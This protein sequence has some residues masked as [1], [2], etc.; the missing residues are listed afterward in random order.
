MTHLNDISKIY[1]EQ[2]AEK[3]DDSYLE[4]DMK[5]RQK[6]NEKAIADMKK[7]K[8][9]TVPRWM[10]EGKKLDPVG[11]EDADIDNDGDVDKSDKYLHK[12]R[13][14]IGKAIDKKKDKCEKCDED[15]CECDDK[16][17]EEGVVVTKRKTLGS[18]FKNDAERQAYLKKLDQKSKERRLNKLRATVEE[19]EEVEEGR[20]SDGAL[21][22]TDRIKMGDGS[23]KSLK[24][25]DAILKDKKPVRKEEVEQID[26]LRVTKLADKSKVKERAKNIK[27]IRDKKAAL[28]DLMKHYKGMKTGVY[29][30]YEPEGEMV[31]E[32]IDVRKQSSK[33]K[34]LGRGSSINPDAKKTGYESPAEFRKTEKKLAPY[35]EAKNVHGE[36]EV[37]SGNIG[38]LA[39]KASKR[40]DTDVDGDVEHN[41]KH[42]GEYGEFVPTPDGKGK[43]FTG[44][45][46]VTKES[47][48]NWRQDLIEVADEEG[49]KQIKE[50][51][52][53]QKNKISINPKLGEAIENLGGT[54]IEE[55]EHE[56]HPVD[57]FE[58][59]VDAEVYFLDDD[60]IESVVEEVILESLEDGYDLDY[61]IESIVESAD[62]SLQ[63]L[64]EVTN[65]AKVAALR[66]R[67][68]AAAA[69]GEGQTSGK[70]AGSIAK[71]RLQKRS[72]DASAASSAKAARRKERIEKVKSTAKKVGSAIKKAGV[73]AAKGA[74]KAG[75]AAVKG[76]TYG[77][78]YTAGS[79]VRGARK[80][81]SAAKKGYE[82]GRKKESDSTPMAT[83]RA[84]ETKSSETPKASGKARGGI[85]RALKKGLKAA[86]RGTAKVISTGAGAVKAGADYVAKRAGDGEVKKKSE[87]KAPKAKKQKKEKK[88]DKSKKLD[89][90][91]SSIRNEEVEQIDE[92]AV[93]KKQQRFMGMVYAAK[94]GEAPASAE[95]A[96]AAAG[97]SKKDAKDFAS[98][99]HK[100]LPEVKESMSSENEMSPQEIQLRKKSAMIDKRLASIRQRTAQK[101]G[102][103]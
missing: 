80:I 57:L 6:N 9:D 4:T 76:A 48:S 19:V 44:P 74:G 11:Q 97:M 14:A 28:A 102:K 3:K 51:P 65:P 81:A 56:Y 73:S 22:P 13:K 32:K 85:R 89:D 62:N 93:S 92:K 99:K 50:M 61:I 67:N 64:N 40:I 16:K 84:P 52:K 25:I 71:A 47:F 75:K 59:I 1:L 86:V 34:S 91:L 42:K 70:D 103:N 94:K 83:T 100:K 17:V 43:V 87:V 58:D 21:R 98:T 95:V 68:K 45:K 54:L 27:S 72:A 53:N 90:L 39:K 60:L 23:L 20:Y 46:K 69:S 10:K 30:S 63:T 36:V 29:N 8:D 101:L 33:R 18:R 2:I 66:A 38:K 24:D 55:V 15:P 5:K 49:E 35:M 26:E 82:A 96:K 7:V 37:P 12:K 77:A 79:A 31:D 41:D 88:K 78:A